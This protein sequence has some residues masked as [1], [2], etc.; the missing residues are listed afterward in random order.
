MTCALGHARLSIL[1]VTNSGAQPMRTSDG[2]Y[3]VVFNGEIYNFIELRSELECFGHTFSGGSDTEVLLAAYVQWGRD[4]LNRFNGMFAFAIWDEQERSLFMARDRFGI[5]PLHYSRW[6][7][8]LYFASELKAFRAIP[9]FPVEMDAENRRKIL[10]D[11]FSVESS[12]STLLRNVGQIRAGGWMFV[13]DLNITSGQWWNLA[14]HLTTPPDTFT[15]QVEKW[16]ELFYDSLQLRLRSDVPIGTALSGG[17]DS[18]AILCSLAEIIRQGRAG[19]Y[20]GA[21]QKAFVASFPGA[22]NDETFE[23]RLVLEKSGV[24]GYIFDMVNFDPV[25]TIEADLNSFEGIYIT[26]PTPAIQIYQQQRAY[27]VRVSLDGHGSDEIMGAYLNPSYEIIRNMPSILKAPFEAVRSLHKLRDELQNEFQLSRWSSYMEAARLIFQQHP[28]LEGIRKWKRGI[29]VRPL[30]VRRHLPLPKM[31]IPEFWQKGE[32]GNHVFYPMLA[33]SILPTLLRN[34]DRASMASGV[35]V[36]MPFLDWRLV[37]YTF[38]LPISSKIC[39][40]RSK[41][42]AR[43]AMT[44]IVPDHIRLSRRKVGFASPLANWMNG[45]LGSWMENFLSEVPNDH[46]LIDVRSLKSQIHR[47]NRNLSWANNNITSRA[48][49]CVNHLWFEIKFTKT[50]GN[51]KID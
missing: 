32:G 10:V 36:R 8:R 24:E 31:D 5:K 19:H 33:L 13:K 39:N 43:E 11:P 28:A 40:G 23:A 27:G 38:S 4:C 17:F 25:E 20:A 50:F 9:G 35:E 47:R 26:P 12:G 48:W 22:Y 42:V 1:D 14:E 34:F 16:R 29:G 45:T 3:H 18:S 7:G 15:A 46:D 2:R 44:G 21:L 51:S 6:N 49:H 30:F 41:W 37:A